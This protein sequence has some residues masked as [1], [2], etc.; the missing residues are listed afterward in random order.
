MHLAHLSIG[1]FRSYATAELA[2]RPGVTVLVGRNG[3]GKTNL[4]EAMG[5]LATL[6]SH[7][8]SQ[9]APLVRFGAQ[10]AIV[11]GRVVRQGRESLVELEIVPVLTSAQ[12][13]E[14]VAPHLDSV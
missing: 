13:R 9:D 3:E 10:R 6:G 14:V 11:R 4:A 7:R 5:Y 2:L 12:T 8:V 1:D